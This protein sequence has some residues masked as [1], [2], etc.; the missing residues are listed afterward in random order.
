M[1]LVLWVPLDEVLD[2][3]VLR[4]FSLR[5]EVPNDFLQLI[6]SFAIFVSLLVIIE[7]FIRVLTSLFHN[8]E[9]IK[10]VFASVSFMLA[11]WILTRRRTVT[12][13]VLLAGSKTWANGSIALLHSIFPCDFFGS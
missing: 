1:A 2:F 9:A 4:W 8:L 13:A 6:N 7:V 10:T 3:L 5:F 11:F 12:F